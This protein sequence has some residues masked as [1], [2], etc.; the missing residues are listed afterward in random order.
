MIRRTTA[1]GFEYEIDREVLEDAEFLELVDDVQHGDTLRVFKLAGKILGE[2][3]KK[4]L[5]DHCRNNKG[6]VPS[7]KIAEEMGEIIEQLSEE[8]ETKN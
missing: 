5:Y 8:P 2:K 7:D 3:Q 1:S 4:A 6:R